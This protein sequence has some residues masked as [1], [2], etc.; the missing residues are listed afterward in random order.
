MDWLKVCIAADPYA[1]EIVSEIL[2]SSGAMGV[3]IEGGP[4]AGE[5]P[6][7]YLDESLLLEQPFFVCAYFPCNGEEQGVLKLIGE[8]IKRVQV[9]GLTIPLGSLEITT[10]RVHEEDWAHAW[11]KYFHSEK[12][13]SYVVVKPSWTEYQPE[14]DEVVVE[15]DPGM[16]FGTGTHETTKMCVGLLEEFMEPGMTVID[17]GCGSGILSVVADKFGAGKVYAFDFDD[18]AINVAR[19]NAGKNDCKSV[20][21]QKSDL[22]AAFPDGEQADIIVANIVADVIIKLAPEAKKVIRH[23]GMLFCSG[24]IDERLPEVERALKDNGFR[25]INIYSDGEWRAIS[26]KY[27]G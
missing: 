22:L 24:I 11:K 19:E 20:T 23:N 1:E 6:G 25:I 7:D 13:S 4:P 2:L 12:I 5:L 27:K 3:N 14:D 16:A 15:L 10:E 8:K 18:V 9:M 26:C 21:V 17:V